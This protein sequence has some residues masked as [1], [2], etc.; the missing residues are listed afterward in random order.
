M[1][2]PAKKPD[3]PARVH[4]L[5]TRARRM[6]WLLVAVAA[7][8]AL[9]VLLP[10]LRARFPGVMDEQLLAKLTFRTLEVGD[11]KVLESITVTPTDGERYTLVYRDQALYLRGADGSLTLINESYSDQIVKAA[12]EIAV[13]DT[14][15]EDVAEVADHLGDMGLEPAQITVQVDYLNGREVTLQIG[16]S[17]PGTTYFYYRW[18]GD[19]GVYM[20]DTGI[21]DAFV[22]TP[23]TLLPVEQPTLVPALIDHATLRMAGGETIEATFTADSTDAWLGTLRQPYHYPMD[24][25]ATTK[26]MEAFR[27]FRLGAK[28][29]PVTA[30]NSAEYGLVTP[31]A[32]L[33]IHQQ[34]GLHSVIGADGVLETQQTGEETIRLRFGAKDGEFFYFCEYAGECYRVSSFLVTAFVQ[35]NAE[36]YLSRAPADLGTARIASIAVQLGEGALDLRAAYTEHVQENNQIET[37]AEGNTVYDVSVTLNGKAIQTDA[38]EALVGRLQQM[39]VSG[40]LT[41]P[42]TPTGTPRWQ[43]TLTTVGGAT[44]TLAAYPMDAFSDVLTVDGVAMHYLNAEAIQIALGELYPVA[45]RITPKAG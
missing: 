30:A 45:A 11:A 24:A 31:T 17:V 8:A 27:N 4:H 44:R 38:F 25:Q 26:L 14:V 40:R 6:L 16:A 10:T 42:V 12:T 3:K 7:A 1:E 43:M 9:V 22:Y 18:S 2:H 13:E 28:V 36:D 33:D 20:C 41:E 39:T 19:Q 37:D 35:A 34:Q 32:V 21:H 29:G 15:T 5:P 23:E